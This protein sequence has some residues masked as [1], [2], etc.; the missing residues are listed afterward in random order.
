MKLLE[1]G[2]NCIGEAGAE[3]KN[4]VSVGNRD[5]I[6][7]NGNSSPESVGIHKLSK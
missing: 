3:G 7:G 6:L 2:T 1:L 4:T 5:R